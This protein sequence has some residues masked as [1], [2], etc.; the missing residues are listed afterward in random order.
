MYNSQEIAKNI[1]NEAKNKEIKLGEM[2]KDLNMHNNTLHNM[3]KSMPSIETIAK[4]A[5]YLDCSLDELLG[6]QKNNAPTDPMTERKSILHQKIDEI[7]D[8]QI[9]SF[10]NLLKAILAVLPPVPTVEDK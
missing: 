4:I 7:P 8:E 2:W 5:D 10:E 9:D 3:Q 6:R 1:K